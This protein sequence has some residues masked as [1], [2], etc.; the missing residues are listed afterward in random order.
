MVIKIFVPFE[1]PQKKQYIMVIGDI[2]RFCLITYLEGFL[3][4]K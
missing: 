3:H 2:S 4:H 1:T